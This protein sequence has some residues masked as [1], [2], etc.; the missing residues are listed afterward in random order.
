MCDDEDYYDEDDDSESLILSI[1]EDGNACIH[2]PDEFVEV[3]AKDMEL[4][5]GFIEKNKEAFKE[6]CEES[7]TPRIEAKE[8]VEKILDEGITYFKSKKREQ[9]QDNG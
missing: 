1:G 7:Q 9:V 8:Y 2:N 3:S 5:K 6:F 4:I